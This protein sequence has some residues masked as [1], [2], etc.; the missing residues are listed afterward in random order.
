MGSSKSVSWVAI[1]F[2][3]VHLNNNGSLVEVE[4]IVNFAFAGDYGSPQPRSCSNAGT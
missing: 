3:F 4:S 2:A 1:E